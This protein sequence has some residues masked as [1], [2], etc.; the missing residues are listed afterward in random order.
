MSGDRLV[1][2]GAALFAL[3]LVGVVLVVVPFWLGDGQAP[4]ALSLLALLAPLG[5]GVALLG[6]LLGSR[7]RSHQ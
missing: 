2:L 5:F 4:L 6:L 1:R 7:S 3:G